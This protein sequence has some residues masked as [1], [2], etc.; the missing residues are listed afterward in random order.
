MLRSHY[1]NFLSGTQAFVNY[2]AIVANVKDMCVNKTC[3]LIINN[4]SI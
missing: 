1:I 4:V 3:S 2:R